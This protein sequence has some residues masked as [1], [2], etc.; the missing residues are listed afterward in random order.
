MKIFSASQIKEWDQHTI[1]N[2]PIVSIDLMERASQT[3]TGWFIQTFGE[4][5]ETVHIFC[6]T[7]N[8]GGDGYV[9][10]RLLHKAGWRVALYASGRAAPGASAEMAAHWIEH[11]A[12]APLASLTR[13]PARLSEH[14]LIIDAI[15]GSG[16]TRPFQDHADLQIALAGIAREAATGRSKVVA[17]DLPSGL[18]CNA[19]NPLGCAVRATITVPFVALNK[20][21]EEHAAREYLG[22][23]IVAGIGV[24]AAF[25]P[26]RDSA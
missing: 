17:V 14:S 5:D 3:F 15:F 4:S 12:V 16:L 2:E 11:G 19:G 26:H 23:I 25:P 21:F 1:E 20:G 22:N 24:P 13:D 8:N 10:A 6:G 9:I 7:G 18:D